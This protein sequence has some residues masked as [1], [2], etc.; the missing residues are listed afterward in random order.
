VRELRRR[1]RIEEIVCFDGGSLFDAVAGRQMIL[2]LRKCGQDGPTTIRRMTLDGAHTPSDLGRMEQTSLVYEK[3]PAQL[4]RGDRIDLEPPADELLA[5]LARHPPLEQL[6]QIRQGIAE[7]PASVTR[8]ANQQHGDRWTVGQGVF[9]LAPR[10]VAALDLP[11]AERWLLRPYHDLCDLARYWMAAEPSRTLVYATAATCGRLDA[12]PA[13]RRH[14]ERFRPILEARRETRLG[15]RAWWQLH[16]P[17]DAELWTAAK[18]IALQMSPRPAVVPA[19]VPAY[20]PFSANVFVPAAGTAEHLYYLAAL[21]NSRVLWKWHLHHAKRRG[22]GLEINGHALARAPIRR[23]DFANPADR[24]AHDRLVRLVG[25][26]LALN[27]QVRAANDPS[28]LR[29]VL[30]SIDRQID[31]GVYRL[32]GLSA[33]EIALV[34][35]GGMGG[36]WRVASDE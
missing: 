27:Q 6:G 24:R 11:E 31:A 29:R 18:I 2:S 5:R 1:T 33:A 25:W 10:E 35:G 7:N 22:V 14:L 23:I 13:L 17:R 36:E 4:F 28:R 12:F 21:L 3:T 34:E 9:A 30:Q 16:W 15:R 32:Y 26:M 19:L 20:V 8:K